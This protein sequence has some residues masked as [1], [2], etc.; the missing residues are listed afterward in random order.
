MV[1]PDFMPAGEKHFMKGILPQA[2]FGRKESGSFAAAVQKAL[3]TAVAQGGTT[4]ATAFTRW[5]GSNRQASLSKPETVRGFTL[6]ELLAV[7]A[8]LAILITLTAAAAQRVM[9]N[10]SLATSANNIRQLAAGAAAYLGDNNYT[11]WRYREA[12][13]DPQ[14]RGVRWWFGFEPLLSLS[15]PEGQRI[16]QPAES[17]LGAYVPGGFRPDPSFRYTGKPF[18]PKYQFGYIGVGYNVLLGGGWMGMN[19]MRYFQLENPHE[20]VVFATSAQVNIFQRPASP[21]NPMI[22]E[23]YGFDQSETTIHFRHHGKAMVVYA[24]GNAGFVEM[25]ESTRDMRAPEANV[26]RFAPRGSFKHLR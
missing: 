14:N 23:F 13:P 11:F 1:F 26:G 4:G 12:V 2:A 22:E 19:P 25:D 17:P 8:I 20:T 15:K 7:V 6:I 5:R 21:S 18:K 16:L 9:L 10:S 24:T 3:C